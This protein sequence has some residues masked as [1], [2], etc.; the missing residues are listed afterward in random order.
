MP[1]ISPDKAPSFP[2]AQVAAV[3]VLLILG[4]FHPALSVSV[5]NALTVPKDP[6]AIGLEQQQPSRLEAVNSALHLAEYRLKQGAWQ[7]AA[8]QAELVL[9]KDK[10]NIKAHAIL[11]V[12]AALGGQQESAEKE[13]A[14]VT[15]KPAAGLYPDLIAAVL[16]GQKKNYQEAQAQLAMVLQK[17]PDHPLAL[18]YSG[19]LDLAQGRLEQAEK[20]LLA[21]L[22]IDPNFAPALAGLGQTYWQGKQTE[23]AVTSY[24]KAIAAEPDTLLYRQQLIA[25][26]KATGQ[27]EAE[28]KASMEMLYFIPGVKERSIEQGLEFLNRGAYDEA[29]NQANTLLNVY[30][31]F[32][33]G[34][35]IK[36]VALINKGQGEA[37]RNSI[38]SL[39]TE[40]GRVAK[41]HHEAGLCYLALNDLDQAEEQFK[42]VLA[43][44]PDN[45]RSF[46][47]L[48]IIEQLR[49][50]RDKALN[51]LGVMLTQNDTP[52]LVHYLRANNYLGEGKLVD[53]QKEMEQGK[54][55]VPG[56][57]SDTLRALPPGKEAV[58]IAEQR[59][60]M[61]LYYLNGWYEQAAQKSAAITKTI[62]TD[63]FALWYNGLARMAQ[64]RYPDALTSLKQLIKLEPDLTAGHM[65]IGHAYT[66]MNDPANALISYKKVAEL[67]PSHV[68]AAI[69]L[70]NIY[71][72]T[73]KD[74][75]A[76][77]WYRKA[78]EIKPESLPGYPPLAILLTEKPDQSPEAL[79]IAEKAV[80]L[81]PRNPE[82]LDALGWV[83]IQQGHLKTGLELVQKAQQLLPHDP[84]VMYHLG[85]G[86]YRDH[87]PE[88]AKKWLQAAMTTSKNFRGRT[89]AEEILGNIAKK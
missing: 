22:R 62:P 71:Y 2:L 60:L 44:D 58:A 61:V 27:K 47:F 18:Y 26:Y 67:A 3:T 68:P 41:T 83:Q 20:T 81:A 51:G 24:Q 14:F 50:N 16:N 21:T 84:L 87:Q 55:L 82:S 57:Q 53:Y 33:G 78:I 85:V 10:E 30:K 31:P 7:G 76:V 43:L 86:Y 32:P 29:I 17:E 89:Q 77:R 1:I 4:G 12:I 35:Y 23:K 70:G 49:G 6:L 79:K 66:L 73:G 88:E 54:A 59:N 45:S 64:K 56:M 8:Q 42:L 40:G 34:H 63:L 19:S 37:A 75:E 74:A 28:N 38:A 72:Q 5:N 69:A 11:G 9:V 36:A 52:A 46:V 48:P 65:E 13:L 80:E 39:L 15:G 25:I